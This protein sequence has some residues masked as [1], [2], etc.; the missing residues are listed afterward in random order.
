[1][2]ALLCAASQDTYHLYMLFD[3]MP[4]GDLMDVLVSRCAAR[5]AALLLSQPAA[6]AL[7]LRGNPAGRRARRCPPA[8]GDRFSSGR[9]CDRWAACEAPPRC[10]C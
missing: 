8:G 7:R 10:A 5:R 9:R 6:P 3:L 4:G 1:M 2:L